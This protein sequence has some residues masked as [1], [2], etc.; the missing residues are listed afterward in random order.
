M[1][2][3]IALATASLLALAAAAQAQDFDPSARA[4]AAGNAVRL[5]PGTTTFSDGTVGEVVT[6]YTTAAPP[7]VGLDIDNFDSQANK[8]KIDGSNAARGYQYMMDSVALRPTY[9]LDDSHVGII[10]GDKA[11]QEADGI[12]G[13]YFSST[14][15]DNP[16]CNF[17]GFSVLEP[18]E[19]FCDVYKNFREETCTIDRQVTVERED[20]WQCDIQEALQTYTCIPDPVTGTCPTTGLPEGDPAKSCSFRS[21]LCS[22]LDTRMVRE[23]ASGFHTGPGADGARSWQHRVTLRQE[24]DGSEQ[25]IW[26]ETHHYEIVWG[27]AVLATVT[28]A[29]WNAGQY[30]AADGCTY[31]K[32]AQLTSGSFGAGTSAIARECPVSYCAEKERTYLCTIQDDCKVLDAAPKCTV[33]E[34]SCIASGGDGCGVER[35]T[36]SC[37]NDLTDYTPAHLLET[38]ILSVEDKLVNGCKPLPSAETCTLSKTECAVGKEIRTIMGFPVTRD[39]W[40]YEETYT[41]IDGTIDDYTDCGPFKAD[42]SCKVFSE[43]CLSF[44]EADETEGATPASCRHWEYGYRCGGEMEMPESCSAVNVCVGGLCEGIEH[45]ANTDF[46]FANAAAWLT[47]LDE[48]AKDSQKDLAMDTVTLFTGTARSCRVYALGALNCCRDSGWAEGILGSCNESELALMDRQQA[49]AAVHVGTY[50]SK[51]VLG[52]CL[53]KRRAY[54]TFNSQLGM[55]FQKE[56]RRLTATGWGSARNPQ[57]AGLPLED[58]ETVDWDQIDLSEAF[59]D[60]MNDAAVPANAAVQDFLQSRLGY[61]DSDI[62]EAD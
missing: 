27:G 24:Q 19:R 31:H 9:D 40:E 23:P 54:C 6:P 43:T 10:A 46:D 3:R 1:K 56:I 16:A 26:V 17:D 2:V 4:R 53:Q 18:F 37:R 38:K 15:S 49:K 20:F 21:D 7:E 58:I 13:S 48:A 57:C 45:E 5:E 28:E 25:I 29:I 42:T 50:C 22:A 30:T 12:A 44:D 61:S 34:S 14:A 39:C 47:M 62:V 60:M 8:V 59:V 11:T 41:C 35:F 51:K 36:Y 32:G 52:V 55:V 33:A